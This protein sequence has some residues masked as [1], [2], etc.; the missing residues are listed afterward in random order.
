M[1]DAVERALGATQE[2]MP[3]VAGIY[4]G[5]ARTYAIVQK[6]DEYEDHADN[7]A[8]MHTDV[9]SV[10][11]WAREERP[12]HEAQAVRLALVRAGFTP[13][14]GE[15]GSEVANQMTWHRASRDYGYTQEVDG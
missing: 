5:T 8:M 14:G 1:I 4:E 13:R 11:I 7:R 6:I 9:I 3:A 10:D 15:E 2:I 12:W